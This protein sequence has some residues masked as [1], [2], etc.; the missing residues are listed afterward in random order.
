MNSLIVA[1]LRTRTSDTGSTSGHNI[2][3]TRGL[4]VEP[5]REYLARLPGGVPAF[6]KVNW[7]L[8][9]VEDAVWEGDEALA[10]GVA[11]GVASEAPGGKPDGVATSECPN[12]MSHET[13]SINKFNAKCH[14]FYYYEPDYIE[15]Y[16]WPRSAH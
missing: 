1:T 12:R 10:S 5:I 13:P 2:R 4:S 3:K 11:S 16:I 14:S 9:D 15:R 6:T 7:G 8:S